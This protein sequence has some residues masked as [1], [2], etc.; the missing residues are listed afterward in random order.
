[1]IGCKPGRI[2]YCVGHS[3]FKQSQNH[4]FNLSKEVYTASQHDSWLFCP[5]GTG[6]WFQ[7]GS[8]AAAPCGTT[9]QPPFL[10]IK[11]R[12]CCN[13]QSYSV[14]AHIPVLK[15]LLIPEVYGKLGS[16]SQATRVVSKSLAQIVIPGLC[17]SST[18]PQAW[19]RH[20]SGTSWRPSFVIWVF[21]QVSQSFFGNQRQWVIIMTWRW[22]CK[23]LG[24]RD[25]IL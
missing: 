3:L 22:V 24:R 1:M 11:S 10:F 6:F 9:F 4:E 20:E 5:W 13:V 2:S 8:A 7:P 19:R 17:S 16:S 12:Q 25:V 21:N 15:M 23:K 18:P 14:E